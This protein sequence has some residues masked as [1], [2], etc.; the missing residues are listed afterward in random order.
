MQIVIFFQIRTWVT[1]QIL[2]IFWANYSDLSRRLVTPHGGDCSDCKGIP[3]KSPKHSGSG[4][5]SIHFAQK[6]KSLELLLHGSV[7]WLSEVVPPMFHYFA[8]I[9]MFPKIVGFPPKSSILIGFSIIFTIQFG[10]P[11]FLETPIYTYKM[12]LFQ[13]S[14][15]IPRGFVGLQGKSHG[16][17]QCL[18]GQCQGRPHRFQYVT[19]ATQNLGKS[20]V[21]FPWKTRKAPQN[22]VGF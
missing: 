6:T 16:T 19:L 4:I 21:F 9:W 2:Y 10:V 1:R 8:Q 7:S 5:G 13:G 12:M 20:W 18:R 14:P 17:L 22:L 11:L 15:P 3:S